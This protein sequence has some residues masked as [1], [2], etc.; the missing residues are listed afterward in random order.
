[1]TVAE[2]KEALDDYGDHVEVK[3]VLVRNH[4]D[5]AIDID[6]VDYR[7]DLD[8]CVGITLVS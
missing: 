8:G 4:E 5:H 3:V 6:E 2:L 1:M 7:N